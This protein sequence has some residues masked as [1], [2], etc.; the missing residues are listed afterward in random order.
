LP[1]TFASLIVLSI[2]AG[3]LIHLAIRRFSNQQEL[4]RIKRRKQA[5]LYELRLFVDEPS[6]ILRA[7]GTLLK[8]NARHIG[9]MLRPLLILA[10]PGIVI[11][12]QLDAYY[13]RLPLQ[14]GQASIV[15]VQSREP[16]TGP[17]PT[18]ELPVGLVAETPPVRALTER[19]VSW[20]I[21]ALYEVKGKM[22]VNLNGAS[23][24][25]SIAA[26]GGHRYLSSRRV[27]RWWDLLWW[28]SEAPLPSSIPIDWIEIGYASTAIDGFGIRLHWV[29]WFLLASLPVVLLLN[30]R[31]GV[32]I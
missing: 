30:Y 4:K 7:Q 18:L 29:W 31:A 17:A 16:L 3:A 21:R 2:A 22:R 9:I 25:K 26:A 27:S 11:Y 12:N 20:R 13:G 28:Q 1:A 23:A 8:E 14:P 10:L 24:D 6:L 5:C 15:T 32:S 19:Q